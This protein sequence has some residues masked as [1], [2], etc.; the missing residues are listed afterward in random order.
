[1][2][3]S[4][5]S[6][7]TKAETVFFREL[8]RS[9][10]PFL[11]VGM[12]SAALQGADLGTQ[13]VDVWFESI[14][15]ER[16]IKAARAAGGSFVWRMD[17]P[18]IEGKGLDRIDVVFRCAG[19]MDFCVEY[20]DGI[21]LKVGDFVLK[22]LPLDRVIASKIAAGRPKDKMVLEALKAALKTLSSLNTK[23]R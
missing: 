11:V 21:D 7:F 4:K 22:L 15:D 12:S 16:I 18:I 20:K 10:M 19:L 8:C 6:P 2:G 1:V 5:I 3:L 23:E 9:G 14:A 13:D 17:P